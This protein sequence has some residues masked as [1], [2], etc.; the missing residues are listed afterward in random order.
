M[1]RRGERERR[2]KD[3]GCW[4]SRI[5]WW[6]CYGWLLSSGSGRKTEANLLLPESI[7][8]LLRKCW[9]LCFFLFLKKKEDVNVS[10]FHCF[11]FSFNFKWSF[12]SVQE[13]SPL[14]AFSLT[15]TLPFF[16]LL[17]ITFSLFTPLIVHL[18]MNIYSHYL[19][20]KPLWTHKMSCH[21]W[22]LYNIKRNT[23]EASQRGKKV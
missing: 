17:L 7:L 23:G 11:H 1:K 13:L 6:P 22:S 10:C 20:K 8:Q 9:N 15:L 4:V 18:H 19:N 21:H 12:K 14:T 3:P 16:F 2:R 5:G